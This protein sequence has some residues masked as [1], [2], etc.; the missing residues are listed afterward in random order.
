MEISAGFLDPPDLHVLS[1]SPVTHLSENIHA[2]HMGEGYAYVTRIFLLI[3]ARALMKL[4]PLVGR[5]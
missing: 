4:M 3:Q 2:G 1:S 5:V